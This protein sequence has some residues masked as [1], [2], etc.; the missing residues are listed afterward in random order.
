MAPDDEKPDVLSSLP[1][2]RPQRR[3]AKRAAPG[4]AAPAKAAAKPAAKPAAKKPAPRKRA[5]A[6]PRIE[7][8]A[9]SIPPA[10]FAP[11][12]DTQDRPAPSGVE[13]VGT[14]IQA[15]GELAQIGAAVGKQA[16]RGALGR[17]G[18]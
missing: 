10:G 14:A 17:L 13:L 16:L 18:R 4:A 15:A 6:K 3:S 5:P 8:V 2:T 12:E 9:P 1:R 11:P 7:A